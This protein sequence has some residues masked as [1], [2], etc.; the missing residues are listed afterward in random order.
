MRLASI[1]I[2]CLLLAV[3]MITAQETLPTPRR[4][5]PTAPETM[6]TPRRLEAIPAIREDGSEDESGA[7][8]TLP[9][10]L[11]QHRAE[12][13][14]LESTFNAV[15]H[16]FSANAGMT[17]DDAE[18][19]SLRLRIHEALARIARKRANPGSLSGAAKGKKAPSLL[20][21]GVE[22]PEQIDSHSDKAVP[23]ATVPKDVGPHALPAG[24]GAG[25]EPAAPKTID[26]TS[27]AY[28]LVRAGKYD[29]AL[30]VYQSI[31]IKETSFDERSTIQYLAATCMRNVGKIDEAT[32]LYRE[33]AN[34]KADPYLATCAQWQLAMLRWEQTMTERLE[35]IRKR[36]SA[37]GTAPG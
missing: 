2:G 32:N 37:M 16:E 11:K 19:A 23:I 9:D 29:A 6:P 18:A 27:V 13:E 3:S 4:L 30:T 15:N 12:R 31:D 22:A 34:A 21:P 25:A 35:E 8:A 36:R 14:A 1:M 26:A 17:P 28:S 33:V 7:K 5:E 24:P 10:L 20:P